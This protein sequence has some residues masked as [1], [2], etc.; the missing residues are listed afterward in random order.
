MPVYDHHKT[1]KSSYLEKDQVP[2]VI[3]KVNLKKN[4]S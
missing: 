3:D 2:L 1:H 4:E